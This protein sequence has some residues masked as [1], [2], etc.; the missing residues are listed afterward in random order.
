MVDA[1]KKIAEHVVNTNETVD[2]FLAKGK[3]AL[4]DGDKLAAAGLWGTG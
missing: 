3:G 4:D 2:V 1:V